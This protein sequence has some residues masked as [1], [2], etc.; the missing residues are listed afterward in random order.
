[1][2]IPPTIVC[3]TELLV[4]GYGNSL[5]GD[6]GIGPMVADAINCLNLPGVRTLSCPLLAPELADPIARAREVIF[7]DASA[8]PLPSVRWQKL[9]PD[10]S[11]QLMA[12]AAE[13]RTLL[14]LAHDLFGH[15]PKAWWLTLPA[16]D[17]GFRSGLSPD[18]EE[19]C[20]AAVRLI[21]NFHCLH[22]RATAC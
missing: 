2:K 12:H 6:D 4:I 16:L 20:C 3:D 17:M 19:H 11:S 18:A 10:E 5:R 14:A 13:P 21:R 1:M 15:A 7:V 22:D 8:E 9:T